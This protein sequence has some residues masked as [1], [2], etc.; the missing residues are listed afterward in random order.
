LAKQTVRWQIGMPLALL[1]MVLIFLPAHAAPTETDLPKLQLVQ[2]RQA[3]S[4]GA[5]AKACELYAEYLSYDRNP[6]VKARFL[7][8][9]RNYHRVLRHSDESYRRQLNGKEFPLRDAFKIYEDILCKIQNVY[10]TSPG[11]T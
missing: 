6:E 11:P 9:L 8:C 4:Q 5:W 1:T 10:M 3:E 2:A 7:L